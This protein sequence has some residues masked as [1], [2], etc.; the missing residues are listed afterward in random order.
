M[1]TLNNLYLKYANEI[2]PVLE[3]DGYFQYL[4]ETLE[5]GQ[6]VMDQQSVVLRKT[7][8]TEWMDV[9][10]DSLDSLF[11]VTATPRR[12]IKT[13]EEIVPV[14]LAK[15][16]TGDSVRHLSQNTQFIAS[17][18]DGNVQPT[19]IL[20]VTVEE[21][22]DLYE[23]RF[24][25]HLIQRLITFIDNRTDI[26]FWVTG[27]ERYSTLKF[28]SAFE[29]D[30]EKIEYEVSMKISDKTEQSAEDKNNM[31]VFARIDRIRRQVMQLRR[32]SFCDVL[33]GCAKVRSPIQR[34]NLLTKDHDYR[35]C[36]DLWQFLE[37]YESIGYSIDE[38]KRALQFDEE[39]I[40]QFYT[41]VIA[42]YATFKSLMDPDKRNLEDDTL[43][44]KVKVRRRPKFYKTI[45][46]EFKE[47]PNLD[48]VEIRKIFVEYVT[49][50]QL[51]AEAKQQEA[52]AAML[53]AEA[54]AAEALKQAEEAEKQRA[55]AQAFAE[56]TERNCKTQ[57]ALARDDA[58]RKVEAA[59]A[60]A[61]AKV[62]SARAEADAKVEATINDANAKVEAAQQDASSKI[63]AARQDAS[64][65][66][67]TARQD[68]AARI[69]AAQSEAEE[70]VRTAELRM[71]AAL[72]DREQALAARAEFERKAIESDEHA[73]KA[74]EE[75]DAAIRAKEMAEA[76][77]LHAENDKA[78]A[79][80]QAEV[81]IQK[82][83]EM[84]ERL[85]NAARIE[86]RRA[87][88]ESEHAAKVL[89]HAEEM[90]ETARKAEE[91]A[92]LAQEEALR[93]GKR[94]EKEA[95]KML[96]RMKDLTLPQYL[97]LRKEIKSKETK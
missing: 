69:E 75:R 46:E 84:S 59:R 62:E 43:R 90:A 14:D 7:V 67:E 92:K 50:A 11:K 66:V 30:A 63:E 36:F 57:I 70:K 85:E 53:A 74:F 18:E 37:R 28:T 48:D 56:L 60:D 68:A 20:N 27:D 39:Y 2:G 1:D 87:R 15:K 10:E 93:A 71:G 8:D 79:I 6:N 40:F 41:N 83:R 81:S 55:E 82:T 3:E 5:S 24:L 21:T 25:Y 49:P 54:K 94:A 73:V 76:I 64:D 33:A 78:F 12:F 86:A 97:A 52:E 44:K 31:E 19:K 4:Y 17:N 88:E 42:N 32:S 13:S 51:E 34:T 58:A 26:I 91:A 65:K 96:S 80:K 23:N 45:K 38:E 72:N 47:S 77:K 29:D 16:I 89:Q 35:K 9:I 61:E 95:L 22:Y